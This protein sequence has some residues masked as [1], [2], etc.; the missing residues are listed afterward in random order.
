M[1]DENFQRR[2]YGKII[3]KKN[4]LSVEVKQGI[5]WLATSLLFLIVILSI[6]FLLNTSQTYQKGNVLQEQQNTKTD[7]ELQNRA[8]INK[9]IQVMSSSKIEANPLLST[10]QT[11][12]NAT[13]IPDPNVPATNTVFPNSRTRK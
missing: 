8:I 1:I 7:L 9:I 5:L 2:R 13:Y 4:P 6:V 11:V 3:T 10:M 12:Q